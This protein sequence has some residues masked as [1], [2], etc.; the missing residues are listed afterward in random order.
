MNRKKSI[1]CAIAFLAIAGVTAFNLNFGSKNSNLSSLALRNIEVLAYG[2]GDGDAIWDRGTADCKYE[3][4]G[5]YPGSTVILG[6]VSIKIGP[7]GN[8]NYTCYEC[9]VTCTIGGYDLC[10]PK[11]CN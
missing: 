3:V 6:G 7:T 8:L 11:N 4:T 5:A 1:L 10:E 2:E 9:N